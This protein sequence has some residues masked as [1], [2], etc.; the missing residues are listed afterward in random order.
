MVM[1]Q[2]N[3]MLLQLQERCCE[4]HSLRFEF[5]FGIRPALLCVGRCEFTLLKS[6]EC[7]GSFRLSMFQ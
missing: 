1:S 7:S 2:I 6:A 5:M 3:G 4:Q